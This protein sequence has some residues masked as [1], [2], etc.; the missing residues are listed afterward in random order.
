MNTMYKITYKK[1]GGQYDTMSIMAANINAAV[2]KF[3]A[4]ENQLGKSLTR[5]YHYSESA[6]TKVEL[7]M[8]G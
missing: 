3:C 4:M 5:K 6:I 2:A 1:V 8:I 7:V